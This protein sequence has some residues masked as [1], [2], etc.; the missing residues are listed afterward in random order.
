MYSHVFRRRL[1]YVTTASST[2]F[3]IILVVSLF[4]CVTVVSSGQAKH[5]SERFWIDK[6]AGSNTSFEG[7]TIDK[8]EMRQHLVPGTYRVLKLDAASFRAF[9]MR[10]PIESET[11]V[12]RGGL[13]VSLPLPNGR[14]SQYR[15]FESSVFTPEL[16]LQYPDIK[17]YKGFGIDDPTATTH[18]EMTSEGFRAMQATQLGNLFI[19]PAINSDRDTLVVYNKRD[20]FRSDKDSFFCSVGGENRK[21]T[22]GDISEAIPQPPVR[23]NRLRTYRLAM[24]VTWGYVSFHFNRGTTAANA[25]ATTISRNNVMYERDLAIR[26]LISATI[27]PTSAANDPYVKSDGTPMTGNE[28][29]AANQGIIDGQVGSGNYD[30]GHVMGTN[31][32]GGRGD[33]GQVCNSGNI[34]IAGRKANGMTFTASP[35][36]DPFDVD[37]VAHEFGHQFGGNHTW[38]AI[39]SGS[40]VA[41]GRSDIASYEIG[42]GTTIMAYAGICGDA[43]LQQNS[44]SYFHAK[45][46]EQILL[47]TTTGDCNCGQEIGAVNQLPF[48]DAG[49]GYNVPAYTPFALTATGSDPDGQPLTYSWQQSNLGD[50][51]PPYGD[52][53]NRPLFR[54]PAG[55]PSTSPTRTFP[56]INYVLN[57]DNSPPDNYTSSNG[58][59]FRTGEVMPFVDQT[60]D[61]TVTARDGA[62]GVALDTTSVYITNTGPSFKVLVPDGGEVW[63]SGADHIIQ[64]RVSGTDAPPISATHVN[65]LLSVDGGVNFSTILTNTPNDGS[66]TVYIGNQSTFYAAARIK[67]EAAGNIFFDISNANFSLRPAYAVSGHVQNRAGQPEPSVTITL[68]ELGTTTTTNAGGNFTI[69]VPGSST[70]S[71]T[72]SRA[73]TTFSPTTLTLPVLSG[74]YSIPDPF[75]TNGEVQIS[76]RIKDQSG[77][78]LSGITVDLNGGE[79]TAVTNANGIYQFDDVIEGSNYTVSPLSGDH[80]FTPLN[81]LIM[82][83]S[84]NTTVPDFTGRSLRHKLVGTIREQGTNQP[85]VG[86]TV[87]LSGTQSG[88]VQTNPMGRYEFPNLHET[89]TYTVTPT[90]GYW[91][92][93]PP[94]QTFNN[95]PGDQ[96]QDFVGISPP[97]IIGT[98]RDICG[99]TVS[100]VAI[101]ANPSGSTVATDG[102]GNFSLPVP[103]GGTYTITP[104]LAGWSFDPANRNIPSIA[105]NVPGQNFLATPPTI[106]YVWTGIGAGTGPNF[107]ASWAN[108][109]NWTVNNQPTNGRFPRC[110]DYAT[111]E[112]STAVHLAGPRTVKRFTYRAG[113]VYG[114]E[115]TVT[116]R[117][118]WH[119]A[120]AANQNALIYNADLTIP[121]GSELHLQGSDRKALHGGVLTNEG[122]IVW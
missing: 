62:G 20:Y 107:D 98:I 105:A 52:N 120:G 67:I 32:S 122:T 7:E 82:N 86:V 74:N 115:L 8:W 97:L 69:I 76:G 17:T 116:E 87:T 27:I 43:D 102:A 64:W 2:Y 1:L 15:V 41:G 93:V 47:T 109:N 10:A 113:E 40:C 42:G 71:L 38:N 54:A 63:N 60:M 16:A 37:Y 21:I 44:D 55:L 11:A 89:G 19:D 80:Q 114:G 81:H 85:V 84:G 66:E 39:N 90:F 72:P 35:V 30:I 79:Q 56:S 31:G 75:L 51:N 111:I 24:G 88:T 73:G 96:T 112:T 92:F 59:I 94:S 108:P 33:I 3:K 95:F 14:F 68:N 57:N 50:S 9:L 53:G 46:V 91:E 45:S 23:P 110:V 121:N 119:G 18:F 70:F 13:V 26:L 29:Y 104:L 83:L 49:T 36:G 117:M 25:I 6:T 78:N 103:R 22:G 118:D 4:L 65:I 100:G 77:A 12:E 28:A 5:D 106:D 61:F 58:S 48:V 101:T 34:F 99:D